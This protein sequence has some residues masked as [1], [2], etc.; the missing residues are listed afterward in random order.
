MN[1]ICL[2]CKYFSMDI[3]VG[4][5]ETPGNGFTAQCIKGHW[6]MVESGNS[7]IPL[8]EYRANMLKGVDCPDNELAVD[9]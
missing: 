9:K 6:Q 8:A 2:F 3:E 5:S 4:W 7:C 1:R